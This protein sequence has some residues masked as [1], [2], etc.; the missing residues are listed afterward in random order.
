MGQNYLHIEIIRMLVLGAK[1]AI[2][3]NAINCAGTSIYWI[4]IHDLMCLSFER[5]GHVNNHIM[6][7]VRN[8]EC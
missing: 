1:F 6:H 8:I 7:L 5:I 4:Q 2:L 3:K